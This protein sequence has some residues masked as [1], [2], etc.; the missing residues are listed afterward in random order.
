M[1]AQTE[2]DCFFM[3]SPDHYPLRKGTAPE[4]GPH[5]RGGVGQENNVSFAVLVPMRPDG[6]IKPLAI[7]EGLPG[8][9][10]PGEPNA[11]CRRCTRFGAA[12]PTLWPLARIRR[13][14]SAD[15]DV[16]MELVVA[17]T[18]THGDHRAGG[19]AGMLVAG[20]VFGKWIC[21]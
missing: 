14:V 11:V 21:S 19:T 9:Y 5:Q 8:A 7:A 10:A 13:V 17:G 2:V 3:D 18:L 16:A 20:L 6:V 15:N 4:M 12:L 1:H